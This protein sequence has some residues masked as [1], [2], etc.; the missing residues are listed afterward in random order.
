MT[1]L[2]D[3]ISNRTSEY[4]YIL[5]LVAL[6]ILSTRTATTLHEVCGHALTAFISGGEVKK[7]TIS[8]FGGGGVNA[9][10]D[11]SNL[12]VAVPY[13][14]SGIWINLLSGFAA[15]V[16][17]KYKKNDNPV[18]NLFLSL[19]GLTSIGG[20]FGYLITG[21]YYDYGDPVSWR[22]TMP[23]WYDSF[24]IV[25]MACLPFAGYLTLKRHAF[26]QE[27]LF[28]VKDWAAR[29]LL[30]AM[31]LGTALALYGA[32][33]LGFNQKLVMIDASGKA[34]ERSQAKVLLQKKTALYEELKRRQPHLSDEA[35][36]AAL[37]GTKIVIDKSEVPRKLPIQPLMLTLFL[38]GGF[39][40]VMKLPEER[41]K[42]D[43]RVVTGKTVAIVWLLAGL[44]LTLL[45]WLQ[46]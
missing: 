45:L 12:W 35:I 2:S 41:Q 1:L 14:F 28:P 16:V 36:E 37:Q 17:L 33:F 25:F 40:G 6:L 18:F 34:F 46:L 42:K 27:R 11:N 38:V 39:W 32:I 7:I 44:T 22:Q 15:L 9:D 31:T 4:L 10:I 26:V 30:M 21:I 20:A 8:L 5:L 19:F 3:I 43:Y 29:S 24:W 23:G 13:A